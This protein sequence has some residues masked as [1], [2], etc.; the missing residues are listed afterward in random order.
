MRAQ[1]RYCSSTLIVILTITQILLIH[2]L[3]DD[4]LLGANR[5]EEDGDMLEDISGDGFE[6]WDY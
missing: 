6:N 5:S 4:I 2:H 1:R 3:I